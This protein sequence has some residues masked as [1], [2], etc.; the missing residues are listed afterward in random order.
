MPL[1]LIH[2]PL[3][4]GR[5]GLV[6]RRFAAVLERDP[7][8]V[9]PN[10]DD[11][12][13]FE[14]ELCEDGAILGGSAMT[15]GALFRTIATVAGAPPGAELSPAQRLRAIAVAV[16]ASIGRLGPLRRSASR[17]GFARAFE[18]LLDEL[19]AAGV[20]PTAVEASAATL[21]GSAY[22]SDIAT[23]F[24]AYADARD[25]I[26]RIDTHGIAREAIALLHRDGG[27][28]G[29]RPLFLYGLDD[30]TPNQLELV[31]ALAAQ[32]EVTVALPFEPGNAALAARARLLV[33]L[34]ERIGV[35]EEELTAADPSNT[36]SALLYHLSRGFG[37]SGPELQ[38]AGA[39][40]GL[41]RSAGTRGEAE[42]IAGEASKLI[43]GGADP[44]QVAVALRD[45]QRR[46]PEIATALEANGI[47][48]ALEAEL[49]VAG[50]AVGG[51][52]VA[53]LEAE[54]GAGRAAD[55][56]RYLRGPSGFSQGRVD[57][58]ERA[59]RR[60]RVQDAETALALWQGEAGKPPRDLK[61]LRAAAERS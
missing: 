2:G 3:N 46:G 6:R 1:K 48:T 45:P 49:P 21:E 53:L 4:S 55:L 42:A 38:P 44:A 16:D 52:L 57:W 26:G 33:E 25:R 17:P 27:F 11:V 36:E 8:L 61:R 54:F 24:A 34:R 22:L 30:L 19:Q 60:G 9:V 41:L 7:I 23:L 15:F 51:A 5:A 50:T 32:T 43:H 47:A 12:F 58:L 10:E 35:V 40:L 56:L 37:A 39:G 13:A 59:L 31:E 14:R 20:E 18:R 29:E 28:W